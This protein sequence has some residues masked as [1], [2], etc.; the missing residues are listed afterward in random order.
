MVGVSLP[1]TGVSLLGT[2]VSLLA[3]TGLTPSSGGI[4]VTGVNVTGAGGLFGANALLAGESQGLGIDFTYPSSGANAGLGSVAVKD[5]THPANN[6]SNATADSFLTQS[7]TSPKFVEQQSGLYGWTPHNLFLQSETLD[8]A[9]WTKSNATITPNVVG[10]L[11]EIVEDNTT[12]AHYITETPATVQGATYT[13]SV[14]MQAAGRTFGFIYYSLASAHVAY[15]D[16]SGGAVG[17]VVGGSATITAIGGGA[18]LC[19]YTFASDQATAVQMGFG[20]ALANGTLSYA[21]DVTKGIDAGKAQFNR[22]TVPTAYHVTTSAAWYGVPIEWNGSGFDALIEPQATNLLLQ[23]QA[24]NTTWAQSSA[25]VSADATTAPDGTTTADK[26]IASAAN[27]DHFLSQT[28]TATDGVFSVFFK[29]AE[30]SKVLL[31][32]VGTANEGMGYDLS[33]GSTHTVTGV[34][35]PSAGSFGIVSLG[36][37]WYRCWMFNA[38][39]TSARIYLLTDFTGSTWSAPGGTGLYAWQADY[40]AGTTIQSPIPTFA[41]TVTRSADNINAATSTFPQGSPAFSMLMSAQLLGL[42]NGRVLADIEASSDAKAGQLY[43]GAAGQLKEFASDTTTQADFNIGNPVTAN[44]NFKVAGRWNTNSFQGAVGGVL[45][46]GDTSGSVPTSLSSLILGKDSASGG[47]LI[48][49]YQ[50][51]LLPRAYSDA[52][53]QAKTQ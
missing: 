48:R 50:F 44:T 6:L 23:S 28:I 9:A 17:T 25:S 29:A 53:L 8:N 4:S 24:F 43:Q 39:S 3:S 1:G 32:T 31:F 19:T 52:E 49:I 26:L 36:N 41:S 22:G 27:A 18:Y 35:A 46:V 15:F 2:T 33:A 13:I 11:D 20:P 10:T 21:G 47:S 16:L 12:N 7:G 34:T 40:I 30:L 38:Q 51:T 5:T 45:G 42:V 14:V 37:G